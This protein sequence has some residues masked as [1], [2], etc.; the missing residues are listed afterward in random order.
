[1]AIDHITHLLHQLNLDPTDEEIDILDGLFDQMKILSDDSDIDELIDQ[2][3]SLNIID[4]E[5]TMKLKNNVIITFRVYNCA[6]YNKEFRPF[7]PQWGSVH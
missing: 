4:N 5:V 2:V 3:E 6:I 1:M 7:V